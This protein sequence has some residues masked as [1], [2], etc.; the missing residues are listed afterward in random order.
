MAL[1]EMRQ[2]GIPPESSLKSG[3]GEAALTDEYD[4][5]LDRACARLPGLASARTWRQP[6]PDE[7]L[8]GE[9]RIIAVLFCGNADRLSHQDAGSAGAGY[10]PW[11]F[12][13]GGL[14]LGSKARFHRGTDKRRRTDDAA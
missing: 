6:C 7:P 1:A 9:C 14:G 13:D 11:C 10:R 8:I 12:T 3:G 4:A 5:A 2:S